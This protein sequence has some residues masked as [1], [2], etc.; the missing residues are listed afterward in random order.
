MRPRKLIFSRKGFDSGSGGGPS[1]IIAGRPVSL[2]IPAGRDPSET[3]YGD[4]GLGELVHRA[5]GGKLGPADKC[6]HDPQFAA[7]LCAFGQCGAAQSH[8]RNQGVDLGDIFL[9]FGLFAE[10]KSGERHHRFFGYLEIC[11]ILDPKNGEPPPSFS[12]RHPHFVEPHGYVGHNCVYVGRGQTTSRAR[13]GLRLTVPG[14]P[15]S[16]WR[17]P[18]WLADGQGPLSY[19]GRA[20]RWLPDRHLRAVSRGQEFVTEIAGNEAAQRWLARIVALID[21]A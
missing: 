2:P 1:P 7:G 3:T 19:H 8:L 13:A 9:F 17:I 4:L 10:E 21:G 18:R 6:H 5:S 14:G 16:L 12:P 20:A 11:A 15:L